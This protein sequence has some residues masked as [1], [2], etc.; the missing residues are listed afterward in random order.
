MRTSFGMLFLGLVFCGFTHSLVAAEG[1]V[2][3]SLRPGMSW[4]VWQLPE[5]ERTVPPK[6][7]TT[8][9]RQKGDLSDA[10]GR[11][12]QRNVMGANFRL[13][14]QVATDSRIT[15]RYVTRRYV[16]VE[17]SA[18]GE[19]L[20]QEI[21]LDEDTP[22]AVERYDRLQEFDW[23]R[24]GDHQGTSTVDGVECDIYMAPLLHIHRDSPLLASMQVPTRLAAIGRVDRF[25][26]RLE[27]PDGVRR[28]A[29]QPVA[30]IPE[31]PTQ[32][33]VLLEAYLERM[34][35]QIDRYALPQ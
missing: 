17:E 32:A 16:F 15:K 31:F 30:S 1:V 21:I 10:S 18:D 2:V 34:Q 7:Q 14:E 3:A 24:P 19:L 26:R 25:P 9:S 20:M 6:L 11:L 28:Y 5:E 22:T 8:G 12:L 33:T 29:P 23:I 13:Q 4:E 35:K 27:G